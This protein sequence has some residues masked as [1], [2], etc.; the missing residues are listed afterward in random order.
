MKKS[1]NKKSKIGRP[2]FVLNERLFIK[3]LE[4][5]KNGEIN[6]LQAMEICKCKKTIYYKYKKIY[7][8]QEA[9]Q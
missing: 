8:Q 7:E 1:N 4:R 9:K 2:P 3:T 5:V 6:N